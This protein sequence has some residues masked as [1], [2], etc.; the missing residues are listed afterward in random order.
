MAWTVIEGNQADIAS[1]I[2]DFEAGVTSIDSFSITNQGRNR[3]I[4]LVE[5]TA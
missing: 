4:A 5:Y 3:V 1:N 2:S